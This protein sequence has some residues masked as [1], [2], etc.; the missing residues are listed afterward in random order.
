MISIHIE[1]TEPDP[2]DDNRIVDQEQNTKGGVK[3]YILGI[4]LILI[5]VFG[6][7]ILTLS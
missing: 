4:A 7:L 5:S 2:L 3:K 6:L 1:P